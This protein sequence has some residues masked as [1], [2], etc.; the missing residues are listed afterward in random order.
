LTRAKTLPRATDDGRAIA[1]TAR[2]LLSRAALR[3][4]VRLLGVS[5]SNLE[6]GDAE[7]LS[8]L[9]DEEEARRARLNAALD[10]IRARFG[11]GALEPALGKVERAGLSLQIKRGED[12]SPAR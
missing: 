6:P 7:Q 2:E 10:E 1:E 3:E 8:L 4:A 12:D 5:V 9:P 11:A